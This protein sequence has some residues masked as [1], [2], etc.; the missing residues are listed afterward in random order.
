ML[1]F[2][3]CHWFSKF[4]NVLWCVGFIFV[5]VHVHVYLATSTS[6]SYASAKLSGYGATARGRDFVP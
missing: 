5:A 3:F 6:V 2:C 4:N 1:S